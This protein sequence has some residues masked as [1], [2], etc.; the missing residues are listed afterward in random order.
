MHFRLM[1]CTSRQIFVLHSIDI[2]VL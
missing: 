2:V 1:K